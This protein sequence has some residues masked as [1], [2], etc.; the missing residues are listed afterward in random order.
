MPSPSKGSTF[1]KAWKHR[2]TAAEPVI[3]NHARS[4]CRT[5]QSTCFEGSQGRLHTS[6]TLIICIR[7]RICQAAFEHCE[8]IVLS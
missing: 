6:A 7:T 2:P 3:R 4:A 5:M 1:C 8:S